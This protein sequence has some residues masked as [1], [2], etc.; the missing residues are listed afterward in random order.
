LAQRLLFNLRSSFSPVGGCVS[1]VCAVVLYATPAYAQVG[2]QASITCPASAISVFPGSSIQSAVNANPG[3]STFCL[4]AGIHSLTSSIVPKT[5]NTF[6][7]EYG[8][9]VDGSSWTQ[10]TADHVALFMAHN[11]DIDL[12][13][14]RNLVIRNAPGKRCIHAFWWMS[15]RWTI[16]HNE[17]T[18]CLSGVSV[19]PRSIL[20]NNYIHHNGGGSDGTVPN[21]GYILTEADDVLIEGNEIAYNGGIQKILGSERVVF[22]RN[23]VHHN[24]MGIWYDGDNVGSLIEENVV[25]DNGGEGIFYEV[26]GQGIIRNNVVRRNGFSCVFLS[27]SRDV[28]V[29]GNTCENN[30]RGVNLFWSCLTSNGY[31][32]D[33]GH[34][35]RNNR[36]HDNT[37]SILGA[38]NGALTAS[39]SVDGR[40]SSA[41][42]APYLTNT[43]G[44]TF[45][46]NRYTVPSGTDGWWY[47]NAPITFS[48]WQALG[49]DADSGEPVPVP[50]PIPPPSSEC[51]TFSSPYPV[52]A[53]ISWTGKNGE[54]DA[55]ITARSA[56]SWVLIDRRKVRSQTTVIMECRAQ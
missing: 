38:P 34:D 5:G 44:N 12:V 17:I 48:Q 55:F 2:P 45:T 18:G 24:G 37:T 54:A 50:G 40:C 53:Q 41:Q 27:T 47:W 6:I 16:E 39:L 51:V 23:F 42:A 14:I 25:E 1:V 36:I 46:A 29:Y 56:E 10:A 33:I 26:S 32:G 30:G 15:D 13:T 49:Q 35:L 43:K 52:G 22:R 19:P 7:G 8:A 31:P 3:A 9:V 20:R 21:G 28:E 11:Q 4:R